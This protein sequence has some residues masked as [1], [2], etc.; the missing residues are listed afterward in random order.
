LI[1]TDLFKTQARI[2]GLSGL[3]PVGH[4]LAATQHV[5]HQAAGWALVQLAVVQKTAFGEYLSA[6]QNQLRCQYSQ[7]S[8]VNFVGHP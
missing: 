6:D 8:H 4:Q 2:R 1:G 7:F 5:F 3:M